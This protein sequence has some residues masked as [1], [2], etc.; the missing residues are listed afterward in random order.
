M[1]VVKLTGGLAM[2]AHHLGYGKRIADNVTV[3]PSG[4]RRANLQYEIDNATPEFGLIVEQ[5][6]EWKKKG[7]DAMRRNSNAMRDEMR[8]LREMV[9]K[10]TAAQAATAPQGANGYKLPPLPAAPPPMETP[11][12]AQA[13]LDIPPPPPRELEMAP[14]GSVWKTRPWNQ[15]RGPR[16]LEVGMVYREGGKWLVSVT[17]IGGHQRHRNMELGTLLSHWERQDNKT[18]DAEV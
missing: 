15:P 3:L 13:V 5:A 11:R 17:V 18:P 10:L 14:Q 6:N 8:S 2:A 9:E 4:R 7:N 12:A 1:P 16:W